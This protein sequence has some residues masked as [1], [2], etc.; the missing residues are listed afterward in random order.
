MK[1]RDFIKTGGA[2]TAGITTIPLWLDNS[3]AL[4]EGVN[5]NIPE[6]FA[7]SKKEMR[8]LIG[9]AMSNGGDSAD[10]FFEYAVNSALQ[11][12][13]NIVKSASRNISLGMGVRV[14]KGDQ[15]GYAHTDDLSFEKMAEAAKTASFIAKNKTRVK[16]VDINPVLKKD[17]YKIT[18]LSVDADFQDKLKLIERANKAA[19]E[20]DS[21]VI[22]NN[23]LYFDEMRHLMYYD[24]KGRYFT[25]IQPMTI[26]R[27]YTIT[28]DGNN[29]QG[30]GS[31][32]AGREGMELYHRQG[33]TP[34]E[35]AIEGA[36]IAVRNLQAV[37]APAGPQTIVLGPG[38]SGVLLH[39]AV[40]HGLEADFNRKDLSN[41]S[42]QVG[43]KVASEHCT[44]IDGGLY[45]NLRGSINIDDE[46]NVPTETVLI[47]KGILKGYMHDEISANAMKSPLTG[48]GRRQSYAHPPMPRMTNTYMHGGNYTPEEV[49]AS[50]NY[51]IYAKRFGGGQ[52]DITKGDFTFGVYEAYLIENGKLTAPLKDVT[53]IGNGP[54]VMRNVTMVANDPTFSPGTWTCGKNGQRV[55]VSVGIPTTRV[56]EITV[57]GTN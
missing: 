1:R 39:E 10:L 46:A 26:L 44:I 9:V 30:A 52:V 29:R 22:N 50:V 3:R 38:E 4:A 45:P 41:Y 57:G 5:V 47:E 49:I 18:D 15:I 7:V 40:G 31:A 54:E 43:K 13:E 56:S 53:L 6:V 2:V 28:A 8:K 14:I 36:T 23:V 34:E 12:E 24:S 33:N 16:I 11:M 51:G 19:R 42:G 37:N 48:N 32:R 55:P 25:D 27:T 20:F 17:L 21:K 35:I